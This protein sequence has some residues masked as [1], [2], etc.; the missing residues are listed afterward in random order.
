[1]KKSLNKKSKLID[2]LLEQE[3]FENKDAAL[4]NIMAGNVILNDNRVDKSGTLVD[5]TKP[6]N[7]RLKNSVMKYVS[8]GGLKLE[9]AIEEFNLDFK[10]KLILD[11]GSSTGGFTDCSLKFGAKFVYAVDVGTNQLHWNL[12]N[13]KK[14]KSIENMH[15][16]NLTL[17]DI[18]NSILDFIVMDV[19][20]ISIKSVVAYLEKFF[21]KNLQLMFLIK[22]QFEVP[23]SAIEK[24]IVNNFLD[25][26]QAV[27]DVVDS[28][29]KYNLF[30]KN[31]ATS[32]IKGA[33][34]N[35]EY[36]A[37]FSFG[38]EDS[39]YKSLIENL[40]LKL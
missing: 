35:I 23:V 12:R 5:I 4:R 11:I 26:Q 6:Y 24:G 10:D 20:F 34:G 13:N 33:K 29:K 27:K 8:R 28:M 15:I 21:N 17:E 30:L 32:P 19:S 7:L 2:L 9:K 14:V 38:E 37:L 3:I 22:P 1:M 16:K 36:L 25:R 40:E 31:L 18:D 39:T